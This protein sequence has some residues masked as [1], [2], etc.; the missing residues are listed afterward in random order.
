MRAL[1]LAALV[2]APGLAAAD[3]VTGRV[4]AFDRVAKVIVFEDRSVWKLGAAEVPEGVEAGDMVT[5]DYT[6]AGD[7]GV[8]EA[9]R[10][11]LA[12]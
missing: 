1:L 11:A 9:I 5:I 7:S 10:V 3:T 6:S 2:L 12:E 8:G 4:L